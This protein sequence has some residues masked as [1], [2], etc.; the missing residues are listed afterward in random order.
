MAPQHEATGGRVR[1]GLCPAEHTV[2]YDVRGVLRFCAGFSCDESAR[3]G[4]GGADMVKVQRPWQRPG[5]LTER[6]PG[7]WSCEFPALRDYV[8]KECARAADGEG[9]H[10][11]LNVHMVRPSADEGEEFLQ[12]C[13]REAQLAVAADFDKRRQAC[14]HSLSSTVSEVDGNLSGTSFHARA[15]SVV[16]SFAEQHSI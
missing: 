5:G 1:I 2:W 12:R 16:C 6:M 7:S 10:Q 8:R 3:R 15:N 4:A 11:N 13:Q 14:A 9:V